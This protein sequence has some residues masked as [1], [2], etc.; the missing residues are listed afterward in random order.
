[1]PSVPRR[2]WAFCAVGRRLHWPFVNVRCPCYT[3]G[4]LAQ[5]GNPFLRKKK[6]FVGWLDSRLQSSR[7]LR[8]HRFHGLLFDGLVFT[9]NILLAARFPRG[10]QELPERTTGLLLLVAILAQFLGV[11]AITGPLRKR[12]IPGTRSNEPCCS[13][14]F[15][16]LLIFLHF[17]LFTVTATLAFG[18]LDIVDL[19]S[20]GGETDLELW[21]GLTMLIA[22]ITT[23]AV[24]RAG[25]RPTRDVQEQ[26]LLPGVEY[27]ADVLLSLSMS[28]ITGFFWD[29]LVIGS[30]D[31]ARRIGFGIRGM[32]L[33]ISLS[34]LFVVFYLPSR[35]LFL[36][37]DSRY[38]GT[39]ARAWL[40]M[41]PLA[42]RVLVG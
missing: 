1:M 18:L 23:Y 7:L 11:L 8:P 37:E 3:P 26:I 36:V 31:S 29:T 15:M 9:G 5:T 25:K 10:G 6:C 19:N 16:G 14:Y 35:Y 39:W 40:V 2:R 12:L 30:V 42:W 38:P 20:T 28:V 13:S 34:L 21:P 27:G 17:I 4:D 32:V 22:G 33:L 24:W 41:L